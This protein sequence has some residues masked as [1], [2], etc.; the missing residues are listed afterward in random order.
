MAFLGACLPFIIPSSF[1]LDRDSIMTVDKKHVNMTGRRSWKQLYVAAILEL[2]PLVLLQRID[3]AEDAILQELVKL[4][5]HDSDGKYL[6]L[7]DALT[8]IGYLRA[9]SNLTGRMPTA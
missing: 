1:S 9:M 4:T 5:R 6:A 3:E 8:V 2:S 7:I